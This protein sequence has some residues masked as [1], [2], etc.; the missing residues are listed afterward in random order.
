MRLQQFQGATSVS[1]SQYLGRE[2]EEVAAEGS[3][4]LLGDSSLAGFESAACDA[5]LIVANPDVQNLG[6]SFVLTPSRYVTLLL[7]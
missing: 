2:E 5:V 7:V 1:S 4:G 3:G 6:D